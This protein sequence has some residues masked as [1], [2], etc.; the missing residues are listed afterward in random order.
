M[1]SKFFIYCLIA[2]ESGGQLD[3]ST[4]V[5]DNGASVGCLQIQTAV[6]DDLNR[7][8]PQYEFTYSDRTNVR[9]SIEM[10]FL[11]MT[12]WGERYEKRTGKKATLE[13]YA[14]IWNGG[15]Y[16]DRKTGVAKDNLNKYLEK[17]Q[18]QIRRNQNAR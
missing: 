6:I 2:V 14:K 9:K 1:I 15:P 8:Y 7:I 13:T 10:A 4:C 3:P 16:A 17:V 12:Y 11:Y 5:G 18:K